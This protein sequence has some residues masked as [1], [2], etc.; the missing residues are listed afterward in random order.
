MSL[1][2]GLVEEDTSVYRNA[3][4]NWFYALNLYQFKNIGASCSTSRAIPMLP[5]CFDG[6][7]LPKL[8]FS[9]EDDR[10]VISGLYAKT[11]ATVIGCAEELSWTGLGWACELR[12]LAPVLAGTSKLRKLN[13]SNNRLRGPFHEALPLFESLAPTLEELQL[14]VNRGLGGRI[15]GEIGKFTKLTRLL[16]QYC[17]LE[18]P[19][20]PEIGNL[21]E[22]ETLALEDNKLTGPIPSEMKRLTRLN[23]LQLYEN[24]ALEKPPGRLL[25]KYGG[26]GGD[27][28]EKVAAFLACL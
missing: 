22:L 15:P 18:G 28:K 19:I 3:F 27:G 4:G 6:E 13:L 8:E 14:D 20:P 24:P 17:A 1:D 7:I 11:F 25:N 2:L 5:E 12:E 26:M 23:D 9:Q 16:L 10:A 21:T